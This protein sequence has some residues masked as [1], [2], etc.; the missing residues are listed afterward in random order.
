[1]GSRGKAPGL[2]SVQMIAMAGRD[3]L[4]IAGWR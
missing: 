3:A 2:R 4:L 1:V